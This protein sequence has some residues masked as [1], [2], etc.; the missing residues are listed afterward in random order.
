M[1]IASS[2]VSYAQI[3]PI[4]CGMKHTLPSI[5]T[6]RGGSCAGT[7]KW[8]TNSNLYI[9]NA[10]QK[11]LLINVNEI[12]IQRHDGT[13]NF[14]DDTDGAAEQK[15]MLDFF[16]SVEKRVNE[17]YST[18]TNPPCSTGF[19]PDTKIQF[20]F[21]RVYYRDPTD[22]YWD[23]CNC[24]G[25]CC[26]G[27]QNWLYEDLD[28]QL[29]PTL[30]KGINVY[31]ST[32]KSAYENYKQFGTSNDQTFAESC[33][34]PWCSEFPSATNLTAPQRIHQG[35]VWIKHWYFKH[36]YTLDTYTVMNW[37]HKEEVA[38]GYAHE[39]GHS[40]M[41]WHNNACSN[42]HVMS[43]QSN[44]PIR[45]YFSPQEIGIMQQTIHLTSTRQYVACDNTVGVDR[46]V[47]TNET[48]DMNTRLYQD[49]VV[50]TGATLKIQCVVEMPVNGKIT[51]ERGARLILDGGT[52]TSP[53]RCEEREHWYGIVVQGNNNI[54][55]TMAMRDE[56]YA[57]KA[58]DPGIVIC[59]L[60]TIEHSVKG[61]TT[62]ALGI[63]WP[64]VQ[65]Y[66]NGVIVATGTTFKNNRL[67]SAEFMQDNIK[68]KK[69][70]NVSRFQD[71]HFIGINDNTKTGVTIWASFGVEFDNCDFTLIKDGGIVGYDAEFDVKKSTFTKVSFGVHNTGTIPLTAKFRATD[72]KFKE[73]LVG[74]YT[75]GVQT[76]KIIHNEFFSSTSLGLHAEGESNY[77]ATNNTFGSGTG[78]ANY[79]TGTGKGFRMS[80]CNRYN[81]GGVG[82]Y[83]QANNK[84]Y[85]FDKEIFNNTQNVTL[86]KSLA[87]VMG[88]LS[89]QG[90]K[91]SPHV[92]LFTLG[93]THNIRTQLQPTQHFK[94][95]YPKDALTNQP[96]AVPSCDL[97]IPCPGISNNFT[98]L[99]ADVN[100]WANECIY[101]PMFTPNPTAQ[102]IMAL[103]QQINQ[104][105]ANGASISRLNELELQRAYNFQ[106]FYD[107]NSEA[108]QRPNLKALFAADP[109]ENS[110]RYLYSIYV[111]EENYDL[112]E[113]TLNRMSN[114]EDDAMF[115]VIQG[116]NLRR[117][118]NKGD[119]QASSS[120]YSTL[121]YA[122]NSGLPSSVYAKSMLNLLRGDFF[123]PSMIDSDAMG[124]T[125]FDAATNY[126]SVVE[127]MIVA[128]NPTLGT[129]T[130]ILP[131]SIKDAVSEAQLI[132]TKGQVLRKMQIN[133]NQAYV[134]DINELKGGVY[135]LVVIKNGAVTAQ[136]RIVKL[137]E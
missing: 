15:E 66:W 4:K 67:K 119:F 32:S 116:I 20:V 70:K 111:Q 109:D 114:N 133:R 92:N 71:C 73:N 82:I 79:A 53:S 93:S 24:Q 12:I 40:L 54:E 8:Q 129:T 80:S 39:L 2:Y 122:V 98:A 107:N 59:K 117:L 120:D 38:K 48:W 41:L 17:L 84:N 128:P 18:I 81:C 137:Q 7:S 118:R 14:G 95:F 26:P 21:N 131:S 86:T 135:F 124:R 100:A 3:P 136:A 11:P 31:F 68:G 130:I 65:Q 27:D 101:T 30:P 69:Y 87:G 89:D 61:I 58:T 134:L 16:T 42:H 75:S 91:N 115:K 44:P 34:M 123:P 126:K 77:E 55:H 132:D 43:E 60:G 76:S 74:I 9:P 22:K 37:I 63:A 110:S 103:S 28:K 102:G 88:E 1:S 78:I 10:Q 104:A 72:N 108:E 106:V 49:V 57:Q 47:S 19:I 96:N 36:I 33:S 105:K 85:D 112:A 13:G 99:P 5:G 64:L 52:I 25:F 125:S 56:G 51:V 83:N 50:K 94:Y 90:A 29:S 35:D 46:T 121:E 23:K 113:S 97:S 127:N 62:D 6:P 45:D